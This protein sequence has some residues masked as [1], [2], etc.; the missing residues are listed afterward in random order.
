MLPLLLLPLAA[1]A[2]VE[3]W[4][5]EGDDAEAM[6]ELND[7]AEEWH[8]HR[9]NLN[10]TASLCDVPIVS[11]F[12][13]RALASYI[14]LH[15]Q[16][17]S[18]AELRFVPGFDS[19]WMARWG[20]CV[21]ARPCPAPRGW[22]LADGHHSLVAGMTDGNLTDADPRALLAYSY[23]LHG[24][25]RL[26]LTADRDPGEPWG[27][28]NFVGWHAMLADVGRL[29]RLI[30]GRYNL[31]FGQGLTLWTGL[32]PFT[33]FGTP[34][35][36]YA[37]GVKASSAF[38]ED[39]GQQGVAASISAGRGWSVQPFASRSDGEW[40]GGAHV[41][42]RKGNLVAGATV[43]AIMLDSL[44]QARALVYNAN[45]FE[46]RRQL[47][48]G[49]DWM[50]SWRGTTLYGEV[51]AGGDGSA[52]A[53]G[54]ARLAASAER[55]L[56]VGGRWLGK[57]YNNLHAQPWFM[58]QPQGELGFTAEGASTLPLGLHGTAML[59]MHRFDMLRYG[60]YMPSSGAW[61][62]LQ[63]KREW[64]NR[65]SASL[66][67]ADRLKERNM[68][69]IDSTAYLDEQTARRQLQAEASWTDG[70]WRCAAKAVAVDFSTEHG[71]RERGAMLAVTVRHNGRRLR[72]DGG[73]E[74]FDVGGYYA[75]IYVSESNLQ[76]NWSMPML[77]G[78][79]ARGYA[80]ARLSLGSHWTLAAKTA[81]THT[82]R[83]GTTTTQPSA[84][85]QMR[86]AL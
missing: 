21:E 24:R 59:D 54:G 25:L 63:L 15:G 57:R 23:N 60:C 73:L 43:A 64:G 55:W 29:E 84:S 51:A 47:N 71:N 77:Y 8:S 2:Q 7:M 17:L 48:C 49:L 3:G 68:P 14:V 31:Q 4:F 34:T 9:I 85:L 18:T 62:R 70:S 56:A 44:P 83:N 1:T 11:P 76:Y 69:N 6:G 45:R 58:G 13:R 42:M 20:D 30:V 46:G 12:Q 22:R 27:Q 39:D 74:L 65:W 35:M 10:D 72:L 28:G 78:R 32:R 75:R 81:L 61:L 67:Y 80:V 53:T 52:A 41:E 79:G 19:A 33:S 86:L 16:L 50:Y 26:R 38:Y 37:A 66:R 36:R 5:D 82:V 40:L